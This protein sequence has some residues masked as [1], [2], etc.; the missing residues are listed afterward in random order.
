MGP[1]HAGRPHEASSGQAARARGL[2]VNAA[3]AL[4]TSQLSSPFVA[5]VACCAV[6]SA[7]LAARAFGSKAHRHNVDTMDAI[8]ALL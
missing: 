7:V 2:E 8:V 6:D 3:R 1:A 5:T 4:I